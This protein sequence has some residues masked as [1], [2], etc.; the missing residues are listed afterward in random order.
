MRRITRRATVL[1]SAGLAAL[2]L[3][4]CSQITALAPVSGGPQST[5]EVAIGNLLTEQKVEVLV[6]PQCV[7]EA[8]EFRCTGST[9]DGSVI[10]GI[11]QAKAPYPLTVTIGDTELY[12]GDA[13]ALID[14]AMEGT[15]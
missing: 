10:L 3:A 9:V 8:A 7:K 15:S 12:S 5:V 2:A 6:L 1:T 14:A 4:G 11:A 13:Q